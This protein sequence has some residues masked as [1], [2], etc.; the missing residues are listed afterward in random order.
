[1]F[2]TRIK[3]EIKSYINGIQTSSIPKTI[4]QAQYKIVKAIRKKGNKIEKAERQLRNNAILAKSRKK[5]M[6]NM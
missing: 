4:Y 5:S 1:M 3:I 2:K 6:E